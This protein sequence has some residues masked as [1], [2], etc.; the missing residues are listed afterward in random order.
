MLSAGLTQCFFS[1][2]STKQVRCLNK[3]RKLTL[4]KL[5]DATI[6]SRCPLF[7][8]RR[9]LPRISNI[10]KRP[11]IHDYFFAASASLLVED[12]IPPLTI[13][14]ILTDIDDQK[15]LRC[16]NGVLLWS[17]SS[18]HHPLANHEGAYHGCRL[19]WRQRT[20]SRLR[21]LSE[22]CLALKRQAITLP[23]SF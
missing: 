7:P 17:L 20:T 3:L 4:A 1:D 15:S 21:K 9:Q 13:S 19:N 16:R 11:S 2:M 22:K 12:G 8:I 6:A 14:N 10:F 18:S 23:S 5:A